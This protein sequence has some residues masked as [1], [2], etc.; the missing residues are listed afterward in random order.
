MRRLNLTLSTAATALLA[1]ACHDATEPGPG[2]NPEFAMGG[3]DFQCTGVATGTFDNVVV[4]SGAFCA[5][6]DATVKGNVKALENSSLIMRRTTVGGNVDV[7]SR[8]TLGSGAVLSSSTVKG[9]IKALEN[10]QLEM[11][12][13][14]ISGN[15]EGDKATLV[16][17]FSEAGRNLVGGNIQIKEADFAVR[18]CGTDLPQG[19]IQLEKNTGL[20]LVGD[21]SCGGGLLGGNTLPKGSIK[22]EENTIPADRRLTIEGNS[23]GENVLVVKNQGPGTKL[24]Q[25]NT[26]GQNLQ[27]FENEPPFVGGPNTAGKAEG[28][29]F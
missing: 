6:I 23:V 21:P 5:L 11:S 26:V 1:A 10:S 3:S 27:C 2:T 19:N 15:V 22:V 25:N 29:C 28:Q 18:V 20:V 17:L 8:G 9:N 16:D 4:P 24:V 12:G 13:M 7:A 14:T